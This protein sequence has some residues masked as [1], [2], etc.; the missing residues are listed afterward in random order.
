MSPIQSSNSDD[1]NDRSE[2]N[3]RFITCRSK[4]FFV[5]DN[6]TKLYIYICNYHWKS[7]LKCTTCFLIYCLVD[8]QNNLPRN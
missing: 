3:Y 4:T 7:V 8:A 6:I 5:L 2:I 1:R